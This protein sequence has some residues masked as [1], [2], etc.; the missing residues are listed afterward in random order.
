MVLSVNLFRATRSLVFVKMHVGT[1]KLERQKTWGKQ[2]Y[3]RGR[4]RDATARGNQI[5]HA[6]TSKEYN[7]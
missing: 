3:S 6:D 2:N 1:Y 4:Q 5:F 7:D